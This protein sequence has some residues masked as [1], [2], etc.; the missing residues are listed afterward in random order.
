[1]PETARLPRHDWRERE[2]AHQTR[3]DELTRGWRERQLTGES[4][5][6]DDFVHTYYPFKA[7]HLRRW[8]P[9]AGVALED[10]AEDER[11]DWRWYRRDANDTMVDAEA[12][13]EARGR[14]IRFITGLLAST[15]ARQGQ[16]GC[17]GLHE[18]AMVYRQGE[19][20]HATPL[21][22][23]QAQTD[24]VV[25]SHRIGC[26]HFDAFRFFT[27]DAAPL[28]TLTPSRENQPELEQPGCLHAG[29]DVYKW[30][31]KLGPLVPGDVLLDCYELARDIRQLDMA[32]SP[33][34]ATTWGAEPVAIETPEG[35]AEYVRRQREFAQRGNALRDRIVAAVTAGVGPLL[36][37]ANS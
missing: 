3:A 30:A 28:N 24:E 1:M 23:T 6:V 37:E 9:G 12:F 29:M 18:W 15:S 20:R 35:K 32:A 4:H 5:P 31:T 13:V 19:H 36:A 33:Y 2:Q 7:S 11:A 26:S 8:H 16:F 14:S 17:F 21:R 25:E 34:D 10:S 22:L 27:P